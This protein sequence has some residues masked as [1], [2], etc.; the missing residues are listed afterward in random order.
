MSVFQPSAKGIVIHYFKV[1]ARNAD[2]ARKLIRQ[3]M[4]KA[5]CW[6]TLNRW[7]E[8]GCIV[9]PIQTEQAL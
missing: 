2:N 6:K 8:A 7:V 4:E 1:T 3:E 9:E 5:E